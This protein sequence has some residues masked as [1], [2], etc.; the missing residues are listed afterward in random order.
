MINTTKIYLVTNIDNNPNKV[1]IGKTK[2][3]RKNKHKKT[4]GSQITYTYIDEVDS[5]NKEDWEP[6][7]SY[8]IEQFKVWGFIVINKNKGGGGPINHSDLSK[9]KLKNI[10]SKPLYQYDL[11]GNFIK[12][13][14]SAK[15]VSEVL[16]I[17]QQNL[18]SCC[19]N[20][21]KTAGKFVWKYEYIENKQYISMYKCIPVY[22]YDLQGNFIKEWKS[23]KEASKMLNI[24]KESISACC[25]GQNKTGGGFIW[26]FKK[27]FG[28]AKIES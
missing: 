4:F 18:C 24:K 3:S 17:K 23:G 9:Q 13:W 1:Y 7:E 6:L 14:K 22:Q 5:L 8:W 21:S 28:K 26:T 15:E 11:E 10:K 19:K 16:N 27:K 25:R 20:K 2:N 12:E